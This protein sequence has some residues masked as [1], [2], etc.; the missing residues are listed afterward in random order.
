MIAIF[1]PNQ[2]VIFPPPCFTIPDPAPSFNASPLSL[3]HAWNQ[4]AG[5]SYAGQ[6]FNI[7]PV[8][9][10][11]SSYARSQTQEGTSSTG[12]FMH[13]T[14]IAV[15]IRL[16]GYYASHNKKYPNHETK[17]A[18]CSPHI[19]CEEYSLGNRQT[20]NRR[21]H[22]LPLSFG[23]YGGHGYRAKSLFDHLAT[24]YNLTASP[25][26]RNFLYHKISCSFQ[27]FLPRTPVLVLP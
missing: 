19:E 9:P 24:R 27:A 6:L 14:Q 26:R 7:T 3:R 25:H 21:P 16:R 13:F 15:K 11:P 12:S 18:E 22:S 20:H 10:A 4:T 17:P 5:S 8:S 1:A 2:L 23:T